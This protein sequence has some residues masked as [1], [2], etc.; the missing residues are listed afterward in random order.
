MV[1]HAGNRPR[2]AVPNQRMISEIS[3][4]RQTG[5]EKLPEKR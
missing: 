2:P 1:I 4:G 3:A 5:G